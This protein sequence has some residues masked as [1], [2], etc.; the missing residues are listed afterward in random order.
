MYGETSIA[1]KLAST[2]GE[3]LKRRN[4]G[5]RIEGLVWKRL[6]VRDQFV[7]ILLKQVEMVDHGSGQFGRGDGMIFRPLIVTDEADQIRGAKHRNRGAFEIQPAV[8]VGEN[9]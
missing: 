7:G 6:T 3:F 1:V 4:E 9:E 5:G 8:A 2:F